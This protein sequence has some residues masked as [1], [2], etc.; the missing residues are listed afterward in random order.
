MKK[1]GVV[2]HI[3]DLMWVGGIFIVLFLVVGFTLFF[4][5][6][7]PS[8][9][10]QVDLDELHLKEAALFHLRIDLKN[11]VEFGKLNVAERIENPDVLSGNVI[12]TCSDY[13]LETDCVNDVVGLEPSTSDFA[14]LWNAGVCE[15]ERVVY[16]IDYT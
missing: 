16:D 12:V 8:Q 13:V 1:K 10:A 9:Q 11:G 3:E 7:L 6:G 4:Q 2:W 15:R 14:C 5:P